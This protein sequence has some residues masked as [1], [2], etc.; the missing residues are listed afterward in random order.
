MKS[1]FPHSQPAKTAKAQTPALR[2]LCFIILAWLATPFTSPQALAAPG[3]QTSITS[4]IALFGKVPSFSLATGTRTTSISDSGLA[5]GGGLLSFF[6]QSNTIDV[7]LFS[8]WGSTLVNTATNERIPYQI[9]ADPGFTTEYRIVPTTTFHYYQ[10][11]LLGFLGLIGDTYKSIPMYFRIPAAN[12]NVGAGMYTDTINVQWSWKVC[13]G[14][15]IFVCLHYDEG[16]VTVPIQVRVE[17]TSDCIIDAPDISFG[18]SPLASGFTPVVQTISIRCTKGSTYSVGLNNGDHASGGQRRLA[19]SGNFLAYEIYRG[20][21][22]AGRWGAL[23]SERRQAGSA[24]VN[25][26]NYS[27][28]DAQGFTYRAEILPAQATPPAGTYTD[29][30]VVDVAF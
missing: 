27:G 9:F 15:N 11:N 1:T 6:G 16:N 2:L 3:C 22:D 7:T 18:S 17:I 4:A 5:C 21:S 13:T 28:N 19:G 26:G 14:V 20:A 30:I 8:S 29:R 23:G 12:L 10:E 25:A 24:D